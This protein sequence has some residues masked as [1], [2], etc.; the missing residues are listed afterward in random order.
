MFKSKTHVLSDAVLAMNPNAIKAKLR[1]IITGKLEE[2]INHEM[3]V[4]HVHWFSTKNG[5]ALITS[6]F[7]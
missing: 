2:I 3:L 6:A 1:F 4:I 7:N 5:I